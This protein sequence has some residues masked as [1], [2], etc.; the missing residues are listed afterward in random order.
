[1]GASAGLHQLS[2]DSTGAFARVFPHFLARAREIMRGLKVHPKFGRISEV[3]GEQER[4][5]GSDATLAAHHFVDAVER[6]VQSA[7]EAGLSEV[8]RF[9]KLGEQDLA[10]MGCDAKF[11]QH[12]GDSSVVIGAANAFTVAVRKFEYNSILLVYADAVVASEV[13]PQLLQSIGGRRS[14]V[15]DRCAGIQQIEFLLYPA[16]KIA[17]N[18]AGRFAV[19]PVVD[20]DSCRIPETGDHEASI[21]EYPRSMYSGEMGAVSVW[22]PI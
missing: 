17:S 11:W 18:S 2:A 22:K 12:S 4:R 20:I 3:L 10:G 16:P 13:P 15:L 5:L 14:Q 19:A 1:L 21:P 8:Q 6:D 7:G 9:E